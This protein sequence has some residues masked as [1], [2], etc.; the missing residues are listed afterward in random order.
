MADPRE[1]KRGG[2]WA[3]TVS[4]THAHPTPGSQTSTTPTILQISKPHPKYQLSTIQIPSLHALLHFRLPPFRT[5]HKHHHIGQ[6]RYK[7]PHA[8]SNHRNPTISGLYARVSGMRT[9]IW[10]I[11][12][13]VSL[14]IRGGHY[15]GRE[16]CWESETKR[17]QGLNKSLMISI[18]TTK[19]IDP[20]G[21]HPC[22]SN[23]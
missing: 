8:H 20:D 13:R 18:L 5:C 15:W 4:A 12:M 14:K 23:E 16:S 17:M 7:H 2:P 6:R 22:P 1:K 19:H 10:L 21:S 3:P 9:G 11:T